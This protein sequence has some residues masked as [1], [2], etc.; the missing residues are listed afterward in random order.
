MEVRVHPLQDLMPERLCVAH[1][2][3]PADT[4]L[5]DFIGTQAAVGRQVPPEQR[6]VEVAAVHVGL[7]GPDKR[8]GGVEEDVNQGFGFV[9]YVE[10]TEVAVQI[11][12]RRRNKMLRKLRVRE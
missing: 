12:P 10:R 8:E 4:I 9:Q 11:H 2:D 6:V 7:V 1:D 3:L 5:P